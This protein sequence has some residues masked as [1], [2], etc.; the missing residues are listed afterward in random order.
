[1]SSVRNEAESG[2]VDRAHPR[3]LLAEAVQRRPLEQRAQRQRAEDEERHDDDDPDEVDDA[4][5][6]LAAP[7][8][9]PHVVERL[10]DAG[11]E[12]E[13]RVGEDERSDHA[14]RAEVRLL[15]PSPGS[16]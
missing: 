2:L 9:L 4:A 8:A 15:P 7:L 10:L 14:D 3:V 1:M 16:V 5:I 12:L 11:E 13:A 6:P